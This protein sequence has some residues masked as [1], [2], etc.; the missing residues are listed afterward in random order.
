MEWAHSENSGGEKQP[1][2]THLENVAALCRG[3]ASKFG[4][5]ELG[6]LCGLLHDLGKLQPDF[7][8]YLLGKAPKPRVSHKAAGAIYGISML[9]LE[10]LAYPLA[11]HHGGLANKSD[12]KILLREWSTNEA[13]LQAIEQAK[14]IIEPTQMAENSMLPPPDSKL[15]VE[16]FIRMLFSAL[17]DADFLDT[18]QHFHPERSKLRR[19]YPSLP[20]LWLRFEKNQAGLT[21]KKDS[22]VNSMR[23]EV[24]VSALRAADEAPGFFRMTVPTGGGKTRSSMAFALKHAIRH[25]MDRVIVAIPYTSITEQSASEGRA[26]RKLV[27]VE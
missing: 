22:P 26:P 8:A 18:E 9:K 27:H 1:L 16:L 25:G 24:Y 12:L 6:Y 23:H 19:G 17:V 20:E 11:G 21:G 4:S 15:R 7:Q 14:G 10:V 13:V 2:K 5:S 3:F